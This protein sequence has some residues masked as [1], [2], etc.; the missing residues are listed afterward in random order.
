MLKA[1]LTAIRALYLYN[2]AQ[3]VHPINVE[4]QCSVISL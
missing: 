2:T 4:K 1:G 3:Q